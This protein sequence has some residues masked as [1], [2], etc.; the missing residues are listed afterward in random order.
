[1]E[2]RQK[3]VSRILQCLSLRYQAGAPCHSGAWGPWAALFRVSAVGES[4]RKRALKQSPGEFDAFP[5]ECRDLEEEV[6]QA[7]KG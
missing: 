4:R 3:H 2:K 6:V 5:P 1:M 7:Q